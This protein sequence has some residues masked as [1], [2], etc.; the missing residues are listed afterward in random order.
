MVLSERASGYHYFQ[1]ILAFL[2]VVPPS[3]CCAAEPCA[4]AEQQLSA[5]MK[6]IEQAN[7]GEAER[8]LTELQGSHPE[9]PDVTLGLGRVRAA[10]GDV[11]SAQKLLSRYTLQVPKDAK[12]HYYLAQFL[13]S[14][15]NYQKHTM[16]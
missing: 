4:G 15:G 6:Q 5:A 13:F 7:F 8:M 2:L 3:Y 14:Q 16:P 11:L 1:P 9:C 12:G 10:Q